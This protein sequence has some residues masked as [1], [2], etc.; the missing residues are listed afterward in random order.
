MHSTDCSLV[1]IMRLLRGLAYYVGSIVETT[2]QSIGAERKTEW[3]GPKKSDER[4]G[5]RESEKNERSG[6]RSGRFLGGERAESAARG[7]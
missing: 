5:D 4:R 6:A 7:R 1:S 2:D 3:S